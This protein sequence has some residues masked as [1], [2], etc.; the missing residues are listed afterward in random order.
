MKVSVS[1][2]T[3]KAAVAPA[4]K[5]AQR[6]GT[7]DLACVL[8]DAKEGLAIEATDVNE[9]SRC[10]VDALVD[11]PGCAMISAKMLSS[12]VGKLP[13]AAVE[14]EAGPAS[15]VVR[16][17]GAVYNVASLDPSRFPRFSAVQGGGSFSMSAAVLGSL[18]KQAAAFASRAASKPVLQGVLV[19]AGDGALK[20]TATDTYHA[21]VYEAAAD[22]D[23]EVSAVMPAGFLSD[24]AKCPGRATVR[25][26]GGKAIV[27]AEGMAMVTRLVEGQYPPFERVM[28]TE[29][30]AAATFAVDDLAVALD[31]SMFADAVG[32]V[33]I[34][35]EGGTATVEGFAK[36]AG[37]FAEGVPCDG[38]VSIVCSPALLR[39]AVT[40]V[41]GGKVE[42]K[43]SGK[44][45]PITVAG[46]LGR[47][48][49]MPMRPSN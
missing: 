42:I 16:C 38:A 1:R 20:L 4:A 13:D 10:I 26:S 6:A 35:C 23:G 9:S 31:R 29:F 8:L 34:A 30:D 3:L 18:F 27:E 17:G 47:A 12:I 5:I 32:A 2:D 11:E 49:V 24:I 39:R 40:S 21:I 22:T 7:A 45:K 44:L 48:I 36:D 28:Q 25:V 41:G 14:I 15:A 43:T 46:A 19:E 37:S 33:E